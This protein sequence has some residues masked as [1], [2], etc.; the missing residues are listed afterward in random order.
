[1]EYGIF[2]NLSHSDYH[3][4]PIQIVSNSYLANLAYCPVKA[5]ILTAETPVMI[6][7]RA[8]HSLLLDGEKV[9][10]EEFAIAP[11]CDRRTKEGKRTWSEFVLMNPTKTIIDTADRD[12]LYNMANAVIRHP[13]AL[14]LLAEGRSEV[15]IF[16]RDE[17][18]GI[19]CKARP[20]RIPAG[21]R[22]TIV[23][24]KS[25]QS[26][27]LPAFTNAGVRYGYFRQAGMYTIGYNNVTNGQVDQFAF[28][29][30]EKVDPWRCEVHT[31]DDTVLDYGKSEYHRLMA[32]EKE[33]REAN[34][35]P[36]YQNAGADVIYLP[37]Y[38][39]AYID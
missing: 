6:T 2:N 14:K 9:F 24:V 17:N 36:H 8:F 19:D 22:G 34:Y 29:C 12:N 30:V 33:C 35:W 5:R 3:N 37:K 21:K 18:T 31:C 25:V 1:M 16:W 28:I 4:L 27:S 20:D 10:N 38:L 32:L 26:A 15:S 23:D 13:L 7:G 39:E 11:V